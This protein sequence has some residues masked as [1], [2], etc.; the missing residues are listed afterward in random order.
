[1]SVAPAEGTEEKGRHMATGEGGK[2]PKGA[3]L[4]ATLLAASALTV[5]AGATIAPSLPAMREAFSGVEGADYLVRLALTTHAVFIALGAPLAGLVADRFGRKPLLAASVVLYGLAGGSGLVLDSLYAILAGRAFLGLAVA[6]VMTSATA[7]IADYFEGDRRARFLGLQAAFTGVGGFVFLTLGGLLAGVDWRGPFLI[8]LAALAL[9]PAVL[10][11]LYEPDR[12]GGEEGAGGPAAAGG[13]GLPWKALGLVYG[14]ALVG[15]VVFY[16]IPTQL[17]FYLESLLGA[18]PAASG[19]A[20]A[21]STLVG[22]ATSTQYGRVKRR[23]SFVAVAALSVSLLGAGLIGVSLSASYAAVV[24]SM[25]VAGLG[26]GLLLPNLSAWVSEVVPAALRGRAIGGMTTA[27]FA[28]QFLSP[29]LTQP[30]VAALGLGAAYA[31]V[32]GLAVLL[33]L[34]TAAA[35]RLGGKAGGNA[36]GEGTPGA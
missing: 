27:V 35:L 18:G 34:G 6:G 14:S 32:G 19:F 9:L 16:T 10:L 5:M 12:S 33:A 8:Y 36:A 21:A 31:A 17:P 13:G 7:L 15:Q 20:I 25:A 11:K 28:G 23:L 22:A 24:A 26:A 30:A 29:V 3:V 4:K 1:M 2:N